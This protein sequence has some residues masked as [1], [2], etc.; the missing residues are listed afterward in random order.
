MDLN[1]SVAYVT[2]GQSGLGAALTATL[3]QRGA[4]KVYAASRH[5][6]PPKD[7][8]IVPVELDVRDVEAVQRAA[9]QA[10]DVTVLVNNAGVHLNTPLLTADLADVREEFETNALGLLTVTRAFAP[11]LAANG[12]GAVL[13]VL[14]LLSWMSAG[15]AYSASK[16]AAWS[17]TNG[18]R[19]ALEPAGT[20]VTALVVGFLDTPM[21]AGYDVPK[22][23]PT[24]VARA[25]LSGLAQGEDEVLADQDSRQAKQMLSG[26]PA[27]LVFG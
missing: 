6:S 12:G 16:A 22:S 9:Q 25:A 2:G 18:L 3:L 15:D 19:A 21:T 23:D 4:T 7:P 14:A 13:N 20:Q 11:V 8:R 5:P 24:A 10:Q 17:M 27:D 1:G 26:P